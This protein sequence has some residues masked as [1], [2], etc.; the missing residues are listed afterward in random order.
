[1]NKK[2]YIVLIALLFSIISSNNVVD[3]KQKTLNDIE[4][5]II[6][7]ENELKKQIQTKVGADQELNNLK[8]KIAEEKKKFKLNKGQAY[9]TSILLENAYFTVDSLKSNLSRINIKKNE[10][11][12]L[13]KEMKYKRTLVSN[14][15][16][17]TNENMLIVKNSINQVL[18][19]LDVI[20]G[21]IQNILK[22]TLFINEPNQIEF[23]IESKS[24]DEF[25]FNSLIY[26]ITINNKKDILNRLYT[27]K[28]K[29]TFN[30][31]EILK[32][33]SSLIKEQN[34]LKSDLL[35]SEKLINRL[36]E[37]LE[38]IDVELSNS[39][40]KYNQINDEYASI[41]NQLD[42]SENRLQNLKDQKNEI[43]QIQKD[44]SDE[45]KRIEYALVL[46]KE[47][48]DKVE[49]ELRKLLLKSSKYTGTDLKKYK[50]S[51]VWPMK[52]KLLT[53]YGLNTSEVGTKFDY[54]FIELVSDEI[55]YLVNEINPNSPNVNI[56]KKFQR[57][58]MGL[59]SGDK[60]Y[61]VFGP[62]TTK[63]W[64]KF[65]NELK[66][67]AEKESIIAIY[68]GI[69]EEIKFIDP[70]TGAL[71]I[72]KHNNQSFSTYSGQIDMIVEKGD[73]VIKGQKIGLIKKDKILAFSLL[74]DGSLVN[75]EEWLISK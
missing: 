74:V 4:K 31:N 21:S 70:I 64:K 8:S 68:D 6:D 41:L 46:K 39:Q 7:L 35:Q 45:R 54:T 42:N 69:V 5:E 72:I 19:S 59:K 56:V 17:S 49:S 27:N 13:I 22:E 14:D 33:Q 53:K 25:I 62:Q 67:N 24:W 63:K 9:T 73:I 23:I 66:K 48:R 57:L 1:M 18:D 75:P 38:L 40:T 3:K 71:I 61:G 26:D 65:N 12:A 58:T 52:G 43:T 32:K 30:Y 29:V 34:K 16:I 15:I 10:T 44:A 37:S 47:S 55:L 2:I 51:L 20:K 60:G 50:K 36:N 11:Q 28:E